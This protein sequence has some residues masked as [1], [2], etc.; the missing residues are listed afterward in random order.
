MIKKEKGIALVSLIITTAVMTIVAS[1]VVNISLNRFEINNLKK[2]YTDIELL[3]DKVSNYYLKHN[4]L[5]VLRDNT[6]TSIQYTY[7]PLNFTKNS[8]DNNVYYILDL[9]AMEG[10][11][12]NYGEEGFKA[13]NTSEDVYIIN[14]ES[15]TIYYVKGRVHK[16]VNYYTLKSNNN[17]TEDSVPPTKPQINIVSG[18]KKVDKDGSVYYTTDVEIEMIPGKDNWSEVKKTT[19]SIN[20]GV[21]I[22]IATLKDNIYTITAKGIHEITLKSY[23][24]SGN[25]SET[26]DTIIKKIVT[27]ADKDGDDA[28]GKVL[29]TTANTDVYDEYGNKIVVPA[30]FKIR[31]DDL[32]NNA[33]TVT[34]GIVIE[35]GSG[36]QFVWVPVG[37]I[38]T[39]KAKT[40]A[41]AKTITLGRYSNFTATNGVYMPDQTAENYATPITISACTEDTTSNHN[42]NYGNSIARDIGAFVT[43]AITNGGYYLGRFEAGKS[44]GKMVCQYNKDVYHP[45]QPEASR[46]SKSMYEDGYSTGTF[47]SDLINSYAWDTAIIFIQTF[48]TK[49]NS[50]SYASTLG[51]AATNASNSKYTGIN[52]LNATGS[53]DEQLN[54]YDMAGNCREWSTE[55]STAPCVTRGGFC[56]GGSSSIT[57]NRGGNSTTASGSYIA[58]RPLLYLAFP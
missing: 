54:I 53:V 14:E 38:Y 49:S 51:L 43:S 25:Y 21:E 4:S 39:D 10:I 18:T 12:L 41:L 31:V 46:L 23:D 24:N 36:N 32:T 33:D 28:E 8:A 56:N 27:L 5:P 37:K 55:T 45:T 17:S 2:M 44:N 35:D 57:M 26:I 1:T 58:F 50:V 47:S 30:G 42:S 52:I 13:P 7:S 3:Q 22:D 15:H 20:G 48:G 40:E 34:E 19:Y 6:N 9:E 29:S 11:S 16:E